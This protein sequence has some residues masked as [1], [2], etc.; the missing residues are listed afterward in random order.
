VPHLKD[1]IGRLLFAVVLVQMLNIAF[2]YD[3][4]Y[5]T[6]K[7]GYRHKID[8]KSGDIVDD[9]VDLVEDAV[10]FIAENVFDMEPEKEAKSPDSHFFENFEL[11]IS[12]LQIPLLGNV[13]FKTI[14]PNFYYIDKISIN[15]SELHSPP[16]KFI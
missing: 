3:N 9:A 10:D 14:N 6:G 5:N 1:K 2:G 11:G 7:S 16:P 12:D 15:Y 4:L 13:T 8:L